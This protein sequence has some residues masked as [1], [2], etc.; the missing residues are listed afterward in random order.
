MNDPQRLLDGGEALTADERR[1]L[2]ADVHRSSPLGAKGAV[3]GALGV[4]ITALT[5]SAHAAAAAAPSLS[6]AAVTA[7][8]IVKWAGTGALLG[9]AVSATVFVAVP[10]GP[11]H[12]TRPS[13][14]VS[15]SVSSAVTPRATVTPDPPA[16]EPPLAAESASPANGDGLRAPAKTASE[17]EGEAQPFAQESESRR[18]ARARTLLRSGDAAGALQE[19]R[20]LEREESRGLLLQEREALLIEAFSALGQREVARDRAALF[21]R[22]YP[23]SP[24]A[25]AVL[26]AAE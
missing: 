4:K 18:V 22:R 1:A 3:W 19:L 21:L 24:H 25:R 8:S 15:S 14:V 9:T 12:S 10:R 16:A 6:G 23:T 2:Q 17:R 13:A 7:L 11:V 20:M 5:A 26:R